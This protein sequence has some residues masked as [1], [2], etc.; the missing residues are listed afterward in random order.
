MILNRLFYCKKLFPKRRIRIFR[1][2]IKVMSWLTLFIVSLTV[3]ALGYLIARFWLEIA[4]ILII[5]RTIFVL[6]T[7]SGVST[8]FWL[9][10]IEGKTDG[11]QQTWIF[12]FIL[13]ST[14]LG[15]ILVIIFDLYKYG[16]G[17]VRDIF[18]IK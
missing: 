14:I 1:Y 7:I 2:K 3:V 4:F 13:Y 8:V 15:I 18:K 10:F 11:W 17:F 5:I 16:V 12:F 9:A 6:T